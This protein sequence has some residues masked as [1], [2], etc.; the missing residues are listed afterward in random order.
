[1][2]LHARVSVACAIA[3]QA[4]IAALP[5]SASGITGGVITYTVARG[6]TLS[7]LAAR[8]GVYASTIV[9][10]NQLDPRRQLEAGRRIRIDNQHIVPATAAP[11]EIVVNVPQRMAFYGDGGRVL[12]YAVAVGRTTWRTPA[13]PFTVVRKQEHPAWHVPDSIR[14]ESAAKG[15]PLPAVVPP[16]P[17]NPLGRF[18]IGL[19][20][21]GIG[22]HGTPFPSTVYS[23]STH[24]CLRMQ[25][26]PIADLYSRVVVGTAGRIVYEPILI[27][28]IGGDVYLEVHE[29]VYRRL[30]GSAHQQAREIA[31]RLGVGDRVDW[32]IA[33]REIDRRAGV[34]RNVRLAPY[35]T[36]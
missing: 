19:S 27:V 18:W 16:G 26:A 24:G 20:L 3:L 6:D 9:T 23:T 21:S 30:P 1:M 34:A 15:R 25:A 28:A 31:A 22:I 11:D 8:F 2:R 14:E 29:D 17:R 10:D 4:I 32:T 7:A 12:G 36:R 33:D 5:A 13:G 35:A